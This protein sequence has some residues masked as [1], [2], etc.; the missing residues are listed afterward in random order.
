MTGH[1]IV[2]E[3]ID[4]AGTTTQVGLLMEALGAA[5]RE[6]HRT[7][8]PSDG[9]VG[10][11]IRAAL[12]DR[13]MLGDGALPYLFAADRFDHLEREIL[14]RVAAGE[15]V[16]SDRYYHSSL[17]YQSLAA[18][19]SHVLQLNEAFRAPD[20]TLFLDLSPEDSLARVDARLAA[21]GGA[22]ERF[23]HL[24]ALRDISAAYGAALA[25]LAGRGERIAPVDARGT[26]REV[27][28]RILDIVH[29]HLPALR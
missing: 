18:P 8:E 22:R 9:P 25:L 29:Q 2:F 3:G 13:A 7:A 14:P 12:G 27:H 20:L 5:G 28:R 4:G 16:I 23:E 11:L 26:P 10:R 24:D 19:I 6:A 17:A 21:E 1:F 15:V